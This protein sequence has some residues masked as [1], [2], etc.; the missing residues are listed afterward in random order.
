VISQS[1]SAS[2]ST[3]RVFQL[4][5]R[6]H[7]RFLSL[8][9]SLWNRQKPNP[10]LRAFFEEVSSYLRFLDILPC[11]ANAWRFS[12]V[13]AS[14]E[15]SLRGKGSLPPLPSMGRVVLM[16][17]MDEGMPVTIH[18]ASQLSL[19]PL[20]GMM[21][22]LETQPGDEWVESTDAPFLALLMATAD[23]HMPVMTSARTP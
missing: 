10:A 11:S 18:M 4:S 19:A 23:S 22:D 7:R 14:G 12:L 21:V 16:N 5:Q 3:V 9:P 6:L 15:A 13:L 1:T 2:A 8:E 20:S 17:L